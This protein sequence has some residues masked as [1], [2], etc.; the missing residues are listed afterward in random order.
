MIGNGRGLFHG[1][2]D[3]FDYSHDRCVRACVRAQEREKQTA[4]TPK[5]IKVSEGENAVR[6]E[7]IISTHIRCMHDTVLYVSTCAL[8]VKHTIKSREFHTTQK[9]IL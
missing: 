8:N 3:I 7:N 4:S 1:A 9:Q 2:L 5:Q 6:F